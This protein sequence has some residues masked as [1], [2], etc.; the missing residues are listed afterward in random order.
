MRKKNQHREDR[1]LKH[2]GEALRNRRISLL[3]SQAE[4]AH[5]ANFHR[6]YITDV[7]SGYRNVTLLTF[8]KIT[9]ALGCALSFPFIESERTMAEEM[10]KSIASKI[11]LKNGQLRNDD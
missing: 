2:I 3:M 1:L 5:R 4:L 9:L 7:E 6:T 11:D 10:R 8:E